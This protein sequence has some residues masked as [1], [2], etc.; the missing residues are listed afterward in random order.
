M[1]GL[2]FLNLSTTRS[3]SETCHRRSNHNSAY[4][5]RNNKLISWLIEPR[6]RRPPPG[7][8]EIFCRRGT[9][10]AHWKS[11][12]RFFRRHGEASA[13]PL[14][15]WLARNIQLTR[16]RSSPAVIDSSRNRPRTP[17]VWSRKRTSSASCRSHIARICLV[18]RSPAALSSFTA[19]NSFRSS[20]VPNLDSAKAR[21]T[22]TAVGHIGL[23]RFLV[24][25]IRLVYTPLPVF[26]NLMTK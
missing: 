13:L 14:G 25:T 3:T 18:V 19:S 4:E 9:K 15:R 6:R 11:N 8:A 5:H 21:E 26:S 20:I 1:P 24:A 12:R 23:L 7:L 10:A 16:F 22:L 2:L 17:P